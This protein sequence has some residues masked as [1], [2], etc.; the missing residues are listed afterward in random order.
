[1]AW[2]RAAAVALLAALAGALRSEPP[3][4]KE[5]YVDVPFDHFD[6]QVQ[7][8]FKL[9]WVG[10]WL[11]GLL[12]WEGGARGVLKLSHGWRWGPGTVLWA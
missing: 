11:C 7:G 12:A 4:W 2:L 3:A 1:M 8:T 10:G 5:L 6:E 9:R